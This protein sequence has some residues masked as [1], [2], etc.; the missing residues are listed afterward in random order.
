MRRLVSS[1][2]CDT[3]TSRHGH[4]ARVGVGALVAV[5][6]SLACGSE[7][8]RGAG[9]EGEDPGADAPKAAPGASSSGGASGSLGGGLHNG[10][11]GAPAADAGAPEPPL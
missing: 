1:E 3:A 8:G 5:L 7:S 10:G 2:S 11:S 4:V 9:F 6:L